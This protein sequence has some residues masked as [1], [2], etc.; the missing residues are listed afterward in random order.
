MLGLQLCRMVTSY[1]QRHTPT[2]QIESLKYDCP[3]LHRIWVPNTMEPKEKK[4]IGFEIIVFG[5][6]LPHKI[7]VSDLRSPNS[8]IQFLYTPNT[9]PIKY[10]LIMYINGILCPKYIFS[11]QTRGAPL[12]ANSR[13]TFRETLEQTVQSTLVHLVSA[14][15]TSVRH[16]I[17][18]FGPRLA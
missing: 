8:Q 14:E 15:A 12:K 2:S 6:I 10:G 18:H 17:L 9:M 3:R 11:A 13:Y 4:K 5:Q 16:F 7:G 1:F